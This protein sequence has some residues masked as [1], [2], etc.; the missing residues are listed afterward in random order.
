ML[1]RNAE[2]KKS[3]FS[4]DFRRLHADGRGYLEANLRISAL[5]SSSFQNYPAFTLNILQKQIL[6]S[7]FLK[8]K[9]SVREV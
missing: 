6:G 4:A 3:F 8:R 2:L 7:V 1:L 5:E 9:F